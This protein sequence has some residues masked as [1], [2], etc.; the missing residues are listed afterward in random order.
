MRLNKIFNKGYLY[1][2]S[3]AFLFGA[4][5]LM[6]R[7]L[8]TMGFDS[9]SCAF[10]RMSL[11]LVVMLAFN[12]FVT[13]QNL[14]LS[15]SDAKRYFFVALFFALNALTLF[16][17]YNY[18]ESGVATSI[19]FVYPAITFV[20]AGVLYKRKPS[21]VDIFCIVASM[22]A[23]YII[24]DFK[25]MNNVAG[26]VLSLAS[27]FAFSA[28]GLL[29]ER[30]K[31][32][33]KSALVKLFYVNLFSAVIIF[34]YSLFQPKGIYVP[35]KDLNAWLLVIIYA[36]FV[37]LGGTLLFQQAICAIGATY[38]SLICTSEIV[39]SIILGFIFLSENLSIKQL[40]AI[41]LIIMSTVV[42][43]LS[44]AKNKN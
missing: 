26:V 36:F 6:T 33:N 15:F 1:A 21:N 31:F 24:M 9:L 14:K 38:S 11:M 42:L 35:S 27:A 29:L 12:Y 32:E 7:V 10:Y 16:A 44:K 18:I 4:M 17:S 34:V 39:V 37:T 28:Y 23:I 19:H 20:A 41:I 22:L 40:I 13:K 25:K 3:A 5:P 8:Y 43:I 30:F 2:T